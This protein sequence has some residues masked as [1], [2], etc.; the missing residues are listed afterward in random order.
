MPEHPA[1]GDRAHSPDLAVEE[2]DAD[3]EIVEESKEAET[4]GPAPSGMEGRLDLSL[5][6]YLIGR[7]HVTNDDLDEYV[8]RGA[9]AHKGFVSRLMP[10]SGARGGA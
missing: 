1:I 9:W 10:C 7:S 8:K 2:T 5:A 6:T 4:A 3:V